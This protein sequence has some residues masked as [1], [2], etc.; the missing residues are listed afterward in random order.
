[1]VTEGW[2]CDTSVM[3]A[4]FVQAD[5]VVVYSYIQCYTLSRL[6]GLGLKK[7]QVSKK[8]VADAE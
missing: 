5:K 3:T 4:A 2:G 1:M 8:L 6:L 7:L